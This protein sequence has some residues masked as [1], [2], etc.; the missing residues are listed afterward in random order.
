MGRAVAP[1]ARRFPESRTV[2]ADLVEQALEVRRQAGLPV[3]D[4]VIART[5]ARLEFAEGA[6]QTCWRTGLK[7]ARAWQEKHPRLT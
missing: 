3:D 6:D 2:T 7:A 1:R 5:R 4:A